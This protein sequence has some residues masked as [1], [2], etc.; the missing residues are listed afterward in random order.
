LKLSEDNYAVACANINV[1]DEEKKLLKAEL[2][3]VSVKASQ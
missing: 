2:E 1:R 3:R